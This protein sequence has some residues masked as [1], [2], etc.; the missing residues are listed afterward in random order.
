MAGGM[1]YAFIVIVEIDLVCSSSQTDRSH[2]E[3]ISGVL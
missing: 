2:Q 1:N 3:E